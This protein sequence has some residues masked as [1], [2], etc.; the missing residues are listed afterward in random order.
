MECRFHAPSRQD[1]SA[2]RSPP[3]QQNGGAWRA[4][5]ASP[6]SSPTDNTGCQYELQ[7]VPQPAG[8]M[9]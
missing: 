7:F 5:G 9:N 1:G 4:S 8:R 6:A 2:S 3:A